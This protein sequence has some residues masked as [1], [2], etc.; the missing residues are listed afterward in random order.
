MVYN[1]IELPKFIKEL[2]DIKTLVDKWIYFIKNAEN[3]D[4]I[5][6]DLK[7]EGLKHAYEDAYRH[8]WTKEELE[9]YHYAE[10]RRQ[11]EKGKTDVAVRKGIEKAI[12]ETVIE[13]FKNNVDIVIIA[14]STK[15]TVKQVTEISKRNGLITK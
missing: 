2:R 4:V 9:A 11:D 13:L 5:P 8:N 10:M 12:E 6:A 14:K 7:D 3:L 1:F 15:L